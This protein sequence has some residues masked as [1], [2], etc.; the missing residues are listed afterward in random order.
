MVRSTPTWTAVG[1]KYM[2][3]KRCDMYKVR[4]NGP[5]MSQPA[6]TIPVLER[7][8]EH[9]STMLPALDNLAARPDNSSVK[10]L[11]ILGARS[12]LLSM[13]RPRIVALLPSALRPAG[14]LP[15][16][17]IS[18]KPDGSWGGA[19]PMGYKLVPTL[20]ATSMLLHL[21]QDVPEQFERAVLLRAT[22]QA[23]SYLSTALRRGVTMPDTVAVELIVPQLLEDIDAC[24]QALS[25]RE[26][27]TGDE[28]PCLF[29]MLLL[30]VR[31][32][33]R[34]QPVPAHC[35]S[36]H[37]S[38]QA[39]PAVQLCHCLEVFARDLPNFSLSGL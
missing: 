4:G 17:L 15:F 9:E 11:P 5:L 34:K 3:I 25:A 6:G 1:M 31:C 10:A 19:V 23:L 29:N 26:L 39:A 37:C 35:K 8:P 28:A 36:A 20:S 7:E 22:R 12:R 33:C 24:L 2:N 21:L 18:N 32:L 27:Y 13:R 14:S 38:S 30:C 16:V